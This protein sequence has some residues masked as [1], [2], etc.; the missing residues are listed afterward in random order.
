MIKRVRW[1]KVF[2]SGLIAAALLLYIGTLVGVFVL[3]IK[4]IGGEVPW[5]LFVAY[6]FALVWAHVM[7]IVWDVEG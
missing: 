6:M 3:G 5:Y 2:G 4:A 1:D 7:I